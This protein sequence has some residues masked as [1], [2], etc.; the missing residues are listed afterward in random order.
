MA[1]VAAKAETAAL[2]LMFPAYLRLLQSVSVNDRLQK[3]IFRLQS[4]QDHVE[5]FR[6]QRLHHLL[7]RR[8]R[9]RRPRSRPRHEKSRHQADA[10]GLASETRQLN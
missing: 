2:C 5:A 1:R 3:L 4:S 8:R 6:M 7:R 10:A 9:R